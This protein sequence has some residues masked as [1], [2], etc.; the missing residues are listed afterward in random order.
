[1]SRTCF[2]TPTS[3]ILHFMYER[4]WNLHSSQHLWTLWIPLS[5]VLLGSEDIVESTDTD[6][7][8]SGYPSLQRMSLTKPL[9]RVG[10]LSEVSKLSTPMRTDVMLIS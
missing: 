5:A 8:I 3:V 4:T 1:M 7:F 9:I 10:D 2:L 6:Q